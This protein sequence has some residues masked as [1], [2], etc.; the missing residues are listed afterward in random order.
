MKRRK[1]STGLRGISAHKATG[2]YEAK[3]AV[4]S[5]TQYNTYYVGL[6]PTIAEAVEAR[7]NFITN[8]F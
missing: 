3:V 4:R 6:Y 5:N 7:Q 8:L 2:K 1:S